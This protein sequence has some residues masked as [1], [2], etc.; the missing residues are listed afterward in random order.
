MRGETG[1]LS[2]P[3]H[4]EASGSFLLL[5][6]RVIKMSMCHW[7]TFMVNGRHGHSRE[8]HTHVM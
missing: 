6:S 4:A 3:E 2:G 5:E 7:G 1:M 8:T